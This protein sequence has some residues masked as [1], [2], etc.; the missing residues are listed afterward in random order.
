R[1]GV[2]RLK[3]TPP[4]R[5]LQ[6][7]YY[8]YYATQVL[9]HVGGPDWKFWN[10]RLRPMLVLTQDKGNTPKHSHLKGSWSP[11]G[12]QHGAAGGRLMMPSLAVL[13][14]EVYSR[15]LPLYR[16]DLDGTKMV[17]K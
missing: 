8:Y 17:G 9:H 13:T 6:S 7:I 12:D 2:E 16:R 1:T 14:L 3:R 10:D 4:P 15:H 11:D 5:G